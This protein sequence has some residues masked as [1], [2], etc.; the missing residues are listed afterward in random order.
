MTLGGNINHGYEDLASLY[1]ASNKAP[2][3]SSLHHPNTHFENVSIFYLPLFNSV[4]TK[5]CSYT[6]KNIGGAFAPP[7][8]VN[9]MVKGK[10]TLEPT[11]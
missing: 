11:M 8:Q 5:T 6:E 10:V 1:S 3:F 4:A 2:I 9:P 7:P